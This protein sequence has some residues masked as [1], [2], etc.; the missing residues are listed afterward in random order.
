MTERRYPVGIQTFSEIVK[1]GYV[2]IDKTDLMWH[3][4]RLSKYIFLSRPRRFGKS[5]LATTLCTFFEG[6]RDLFEGLKVMTLEKEWKKYPVFHIDVSM[7]KGQD[8]VEMLRNAL[9][10]QLEPFIDQYGIRP[11]EKTPGAIFSGLIR[12]AYQQTG[13]QVVVVIDEYDAPLL[14]VLHEEEQLPGFRRVMQ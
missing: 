8:N 1:E 10:G 5:L 7:A 2:Y 13:S 14:D 3:M 4:Q 12:R 11:S 6:R 9:Y